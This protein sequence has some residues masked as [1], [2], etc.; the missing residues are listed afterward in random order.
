[1]AYDK[2]KTNFDRA[3]CLRRFRVNV[4]LVMS[5]LRSDTSL[6]YFSILIVVMKSRR[7]AQ[8]RRYL[9]QVEAPLADEMTHNEQ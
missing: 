2:K 7:N 1:M 6:Q 3:Q 5:L 8:E 4:I 9:T